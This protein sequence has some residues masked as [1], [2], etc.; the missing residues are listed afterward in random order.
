MVVVDAVS[1]LVPGVLAGVEAWSDES[2]VHGL[3]EY[4]QYTRPPEFMGR[5]VPEILTSGHHA[6]ITKWRKKQSLLRTQFK[7]P[8]LYEKYEL[9]KEDQ[10]LL[11]N[12]S[13]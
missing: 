5:C 11:K 7:R 9:T 10:K 8:D 6:N 12:D 1:R 3:L 4:P 13:I 2:H